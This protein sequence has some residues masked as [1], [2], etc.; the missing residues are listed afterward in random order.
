MSLKNGSTGKWKLQEVPENVLPGICL[1]DALAL[2]KLAHKAK[3]RL[4]K[5]QPGTCKER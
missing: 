2:E 1:W 5:N 4:N 3:R